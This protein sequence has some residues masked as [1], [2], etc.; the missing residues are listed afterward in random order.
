MDIWQGAYTAL[1]YDSARRTD[2]SAAGGSE[3]RHQD[4]NRDRVVNQSRQFARDNELYRGVLDV[5]CRHIVGDGWKLQA[6]S[7]N[8]NWNGR[9]EGLW[10]E[11]WRAPDVTGVLHGAGLES[12]MVRELLTC[13]DTLLI[14]TAAGLQH[15]ESEQITRGHSLGTDGIETD[16][17]GRPERYWVAPYGRG[18]MVQGAQAEAYRPEDVIFLSRPERPSGLRGMPALQ[19]AFPMMHRIADVLDSEAI[20]WQTLARFAL[21]VTRDDPMAAFGEGETDSDAEDGDLADRVVDL[22]YATIFHGQPGE[23]IEGITRNIPGSDFT[24]TLRTFLRMLGLPIGLPLELVLLDWSQ[25][26]YSQSRAILEQAAQ[27]FRQW[28]TLFR[29]RF[30]DAVLEW[31]LN[32]W[33]AQS[34]NGLRRRQHNPRTDWEWIVPTPPWIDMLKETQAWG[35]R[36]D[37][38]FGTH[39]GACK[40]QGLERG[41][42]VA[43]R[44]REVREAIA[45]AQQVS[46]ETGQDVP[47]QIFAGLTPDGSTVERTTTEGAD[48]PE[49]QPGESDD[50]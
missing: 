21:A 38:G 32:E 33:Y 45:T 14:K 25:A 10:E 23:K 6:V 34:G 22:G 48:R 7:D 43:M 26:N 50:E 13:G 8:A 15:V 46:R 1:G 20:S 19:A 9:V 24:Q 44:E 39:T 35:A 5:A 4:H 42:V 12:Q 31:K 36:L 11:F 40:S 16:S 49:R 27:V 41:N 37:R 2:V 18:G 28:Q 29:I 3:V 30:Y 47:W 17:L